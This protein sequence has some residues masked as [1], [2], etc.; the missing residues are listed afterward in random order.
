[1]TEQPD[2]RGP[3][4]SLI[5]AMDRNRV[6]GT[7]GRLPWH[8]PEDLK[9]FR[10]LTLGHHVVMGRKTWE[11]IGRALPGRTNIVVT[12]DRSFAAEGVLVA[13]SLEAALALAVGDAEVFVIGGGELYAQAL[14]LADRLYVTEVHGDFAGDTRFPEPP[15]GAWREV[16]REHRAQAGAGYSGFEYVVLERVAARVAGTSSVL[17]GTSD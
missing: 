13:H 17:S 4:V 3:V 12:R 1:V 16:S 6:I 14:P 10:R 5:V 11:S 15:A 8:I 9:R 2:R 7:R